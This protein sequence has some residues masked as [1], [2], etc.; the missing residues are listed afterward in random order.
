M[1]SYLR[2]EVVLVHSPFS[3]L[4]A[5]KVRPAVVVHAPHIS[6]DNFSALLKAQADLIKRL[7]Q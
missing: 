3:D 4:P 1:P 5:T 6:Q 2:N 7:L